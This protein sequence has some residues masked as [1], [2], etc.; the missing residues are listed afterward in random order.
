MRTGAD[1]S[2]KETGIMRPLLI[3]QNI[4]RARKKL[5]GLTGDK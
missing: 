2:E 3:Q 5:E 4:D 1:E